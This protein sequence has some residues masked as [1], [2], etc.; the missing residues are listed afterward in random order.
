MRHPW[1]LVFG[2]LSGAIA[3]AGGDPNEA[4]GDSDPYPAGGAVGGG[5]DSLIEEPATG[6]GGLRECPGWPGEGGHGGAQ[7]GA[8]G[9]GGEGSSPP[10][11]EGAL[12]LQ[13]PECPAEMPS[14]GPCEGPAFP[15]ECLYPLDGEC[16][17]AWGCRLGIWSP[18]RKR[19]PESGELWGGP[20]EACPTIAPVSTTPCDA[21]I[22]CEY[23][24]CSYDDRHASSPWIS[25]TATCVCGRWDVEY[26]GCPLV[27]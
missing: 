2:I 23:S 13:L 11:S 16:Y 18:L 21:P 25:S 14:V 20:P 22:E 4:P 10:K 26:H 9:L 15:V 12:P 5:V 27:P 1:F 8:G 24:H 6:T 19:C 3:C 7:G 17:R